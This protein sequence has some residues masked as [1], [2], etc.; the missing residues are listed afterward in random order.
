MSELIKRGDAYYFRVRVPSDLL[1]TFHGRRQIWRS[2]HTKQIEIAKER[3]IILGNRISNF[4]SV[5]RSGIMT[6]EQMKLLAV[7]FLREQLTAFD[8]ARSQPQQTEEEKHWNQSDLSTFDTIIADLQKDLSRTPDDAYL[9]KGIMDDVL[10]SN[11]TL[12]VEKGSTEYYRL[13]R[14]FT[15]AFLE[16]TRIEKERR[17]GNYANEFDSL[18]HVA[19]HPVSE[20]QPNVAAQ[21][22]KLI[23]EVITAYISEKN[24]G[25]RWDPKTKQ[26]NESA[27][28]L[29]VE[30][31]GDQP[32]AS[33]THQQM[34]S[35][36]DTLKRLPTNRSKFYP[37]QSIDS[38]LRLKN[39]KPMSITTVN[40]ILTRMASFWHWAEIHEYVEKSP[41]RHLS[42]P[43]SKRADEERSVYTD[44]E[45]QLLL[46]SVA[47]RSRPSSHPERVWIT[48]IALHS[49]MRPNE[50][51]QLYLDDVLKEDGVLCLRVNDTHPDQ[52]VKNK[53]ARRLVP[54]HPLLVEFGFE[55][56]VKLVSHNRT[57]RLFPKLH[58]H[59]DGYLAYFGRWMQDLNR[60]CVTKD[61]SKTFYSLRHNVVTALKDAQIDFTIIA[62]IVGHTVPGETLGRYGKA[63]KPQG[64]LNALKSL[65][66]K[67]DFAKIQMAA[68][69]TYS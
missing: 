45:L 1:N 51:A 9:V 62:E 41:A 11:S 19:A 69:A 17:R 8:K 61:R 46:D 57:H 30:I 42:L 24:S 29:M 4:F 27:L 49:G 14:H 67:V 59:R 35:L 66:Y 15:Q 40:N 63:M 13:L 16:F 6:E 2:L 32:A 12:K 44:K 36:R 38:V 50:I 18:L 5:L 39:I 65:K 53:R 7:D 21:A 55:R 3:R 22:S 68:K 25:E 54:V 56:Y 48:L 20:R 33:V 10:S 64:L 26:Q 23:S 37:D 31:L 28:S 34:M 58:H 60:E 43:T 52:K 47:E